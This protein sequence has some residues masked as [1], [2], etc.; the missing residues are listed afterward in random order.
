ME[1]I[2]IRRF[3]IA[4]IPEDAE[5]LVL[6]VDDPDAPAGTWTHWTIWNITPHINDIS[7]NSIPNRASWDPNSPL[8]AAPGDGRPDRFW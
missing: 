4:D 1:K 5:S 8:S 7:E 2:S 6:I 3:Q